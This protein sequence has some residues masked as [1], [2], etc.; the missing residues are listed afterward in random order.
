MLHFAIMSPLQNNPTGSYGSL[1]EDFNYLYSESQKGS[2]GNCSVLWIPG[3]AP[4]LPPH[5]RPP[6]TPIIL[7]YRIPV[8]PVC[9]RCVKCNKEPWDYAE[10]VKQLVDHSEA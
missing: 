10:N 5:P 1:S 9:K 4:S 2:G 7:M 6:R 3:S 8:R